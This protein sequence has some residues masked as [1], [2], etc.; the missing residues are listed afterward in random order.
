M[1]K[2]P[3][4]LNERSII[5][6]MEIFGLSRDFAGKDKAGKKLKS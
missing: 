2:N 6:I 3:N 5:F 4:I 1:I